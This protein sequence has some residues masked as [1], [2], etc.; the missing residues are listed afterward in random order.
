MT[1]KRRELKFKLKRDTFVLSI[2]NIELS[3]NESFFTGLFC[4][5]VLEIV[6]EKAAR[7]ITSSIWLNIKKILKDK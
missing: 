7:S 5:D 3:S 1:D 6:G 4:E 2:S